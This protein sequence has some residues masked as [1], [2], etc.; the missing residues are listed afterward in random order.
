M[1]GAHRRD[2][3][4]DLL[5]A[6]DMLTLPEPEVPEHYFETVAEVVGKDPAAFVRAFS[7]TTWGPVTDAVKKERLPQLVEVAN[8]LLDRIAATENIEID[9]RWLRIDWMDPWTLDLAMDGIVPV[10]RLM[11]VLVSGDDQTGPHGEPV[12]RLAVEKFGVDG[13]G[14]FLMSTR[15]F[16]LLQSDIDED[17]GKA[18]ALK[19]LKNPLQKG[20]T[21]KELDLFFRD[22]FEESEEELKTKTK[23]HRVWTGRSKKQNREVRSL[24]VTLV[25]D[26]VVGW[27]DKRKNV[28]DET[29]PENLRPRE[30]VWGTTSVLFEAV[31]ATMWMCE[32]GGMSD[33]D[34]E[35]VLA[36]L[37]AYGREDDRFGLYKIPR[38][39]ARRKA[40]FDRFLSLLNGAMLGVPD[41]L[42]ER[43]STW[44]QQERDGVL[45]AAKPQAQ[46][47]DEAEPATPEAR[48][49][50]PS[51][52][53][54][55]D[56]HQGCLP[57]LL[58]KL[59]AR[60]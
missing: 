1:G 4:G 15:A 49:V 2:F 18:R 19:L 21:T 33:A 9:F 24:R 22:D 34:R 32:K 39:A 5:H 37:L 35:T 25:N 51:A 48:D 6:D 56:E 53:N 7:S 59:F 20:M 60:G 11:D 52:K 36:T 12:I 17:L 29:R 47:P 57:R 27:E 46:P 43:V 14:D 55:L 40:L 38:G 31:V 8:A 30:G 16:H 42:S 13:A 44:M 23:T 28:T 54:P 41:D 45:G 10:D 26:E 3:P 58:A 50:V